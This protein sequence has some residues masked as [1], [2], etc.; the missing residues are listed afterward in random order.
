MECRAETELAY[1]AGFF[2]ADGSI[3]ILR[4][5]NKKT[6]QLYYQLLLSLVA[7][8]P[9]V[10]YTFQHHFGGT[11]NF[12]RRRGGRS[13]QQVYPHWHIRGDGA[14]N[15]L[16]AIMPYLRLKYAEAVVAL[17]FREHKERWW[18]IN[19]KGCRLTD[20]EQVWRER[21]YQ[22]LKDIKQKRI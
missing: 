10:C 22:L 6:G 3:A 11:V 1:L 2:D 17:A 13:P 20:E 19:G 15:C 9:K 12:D 16:Y 7:K 18:A 8:K 21:A 14:K 4:N 5:Y